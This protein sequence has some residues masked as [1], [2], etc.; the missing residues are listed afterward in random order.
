VVLLILFLG[1]LLL[2]LVKIPQRIYIFVVSLA[3][4]I[5]AGKMAIERIPV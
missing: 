3:V 2:D 4:F 5:W 1:K